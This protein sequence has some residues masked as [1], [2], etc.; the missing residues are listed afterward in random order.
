ME[1]VSDNILVLVPGDE[2][3][4]GTENSIKILLLGSIDT[5]EDKKFD[6]ASKFIEG[7]QKI[8]DPKNGI[9]QYQGFNYIIINGTITSPGAVP[10]IMNPEFT[11]K[12]QWLY[13]ML[14]ATDCI[15]MNFLKNSTAPIPLYWLGYCCASGKL[16]CRCSEHYYMYGLVRFTCQVNNV[17]LLSGKC[18]TVFDALNTLAAFTPKFQQINKYQLPE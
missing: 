16:V 5:R 12:M 3:P 15:F 4:E 14:A 6:W 8:V 10:N 7:L 2:I 17:P 18:A 9:L 11:G 13:S 1:Q